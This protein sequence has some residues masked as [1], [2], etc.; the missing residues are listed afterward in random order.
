MYFV[1]T[2]NVCTVYIM[3][4]NTY[5]RTIMPDT[6]CSNHLTQFD[7]HS[8]GEQQH[9]IISHFGH[10][11]FIIRITDFGDIFVKKGGIKFNARETCTVYILCQL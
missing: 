4:S 9:T 6:A 1:F 8:P 10:T 11:N 5:K 3:I 7:E 2:F